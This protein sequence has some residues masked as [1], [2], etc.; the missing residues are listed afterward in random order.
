MIVSDSTTLIILFDL[1]QTELLSNLFDKVILPEAV[2]RELTAKTP[3]DLPD[4]MEIKLVTETTELETLTRLLDRG[5]SEAILLA[6]ELN[7]PLVIDEK[8]GR[9][10]ARLK[11]VDILGLLGV[12]FLNLKRGFLSVEAAR[13]F[14]K[15]ARNHGYRIADRLIDEMF[16]HLETK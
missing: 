13:E 3:V 10:I 15:S 16:E 7:L 8:K 9:K 2:Y 12:V 5:E 11:G 14:L 1:Q 4:F 6:L